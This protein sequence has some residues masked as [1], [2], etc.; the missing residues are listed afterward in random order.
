MPAPRSRPD[1]SPPA[2]GR[3]GRERAGRSRDRRGRGA[4]GPQ[5][6]P[7]PLT[8]TGL[9]S[10]A[11][12]SEEFDGW[13][14]TAAARLRRHVGADL[15]PVQFGVEEVPVLPD[16]WEHEVPLCT[17]VAATTRQP[18]RVVVYRLP[19]LGRVRGR[20]ETGSLLL[21]LLVEEVADLLVRDPDELDPRLG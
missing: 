18:A 4:R 14:E 3:T 6:L 17:H 7:G 20:V 15:E 12:P 13:V 19:V 9:P 5:S 21:D 16:D 1:D 8:P 10:R 2:T 11:T